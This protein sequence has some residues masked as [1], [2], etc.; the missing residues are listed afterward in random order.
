MQPHEDGAM[1]AVGD[2]R[3]L[4]GEEQV[5]PLYAEDIAVTKRKR[6]KSVVRVATVTHSRDQLIDEELAH[7]HVEVQRVPVNRYVETMPVVREEGDLTIMPVIE[8]IVVVERRLLLRE[9][10]HIRRV[11][12]T[13]RHKETVQ[14]REQEAVITRL[15]AGEQ[16]AP[17]PLV[18]IATPTL[19]TE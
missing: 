3:P 10:V 2:R 1:A 16:T 5:V 18:Q 17:V 12:T 8:E 6:E 9:E 14:V 19:E 7:E 15:P 13:E 4:S 11:R